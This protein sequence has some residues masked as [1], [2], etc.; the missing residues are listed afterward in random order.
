MLRA[1]ISQTASKIPHS[2]RG[3]PEK[4]AGRLSLSKSS[5]SSKKDHASSE[6]NPL[7]ESDGWEDIDTFLYA[8]E[9]TESWIFSRIIQSIW[10]QV[11]FHDVL[12][13]SLV[14][15]FIRFLNDHNLKGVCVYIYLYIL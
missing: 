8:L 4:V 12:C 1:I 7:E 10:W 15:F 11:N 9:R 2:E 3:P 6:I 5:T 14:F 13:I